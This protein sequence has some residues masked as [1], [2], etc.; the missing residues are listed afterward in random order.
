MTAVPTTPGNVAYPPPMLMPAT[1]PCL[2]ACVPSA[3][4][5][6]AAE[7][8]LTV[9]TQSPAAQTLPCDAVRIRMSVTIPP[10]TPILTPAS[11]ASAVL[12]RTPSPSTTT[13]AGIS[14]LA[15]TTPMASPPAPVRIP[16][17][18]SSVCRVMPRPRT[19]P[20]TSP[21]TSGSSVDIGCGAASTTVTSRPRSTNASAISSPM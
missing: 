19:A 3:T 13:S 5:T 10:V 17:T 16:V 21:P 4:C 20:A 1:R 18:C 14:R 12:G 11:R 2:L 15:V 7:T 8:R 9:C 6:G